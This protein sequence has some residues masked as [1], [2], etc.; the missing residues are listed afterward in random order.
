MLVKKIKIKMFS[1]LTEPVV[2]SAEPE[3]APAVEATP[4]LTPPPLPQ[5][6]TA[7]NSNGTVNWPA[8]V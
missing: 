8:L 2:E 3:S 1:C 5:E 7:E 6:P 4:T